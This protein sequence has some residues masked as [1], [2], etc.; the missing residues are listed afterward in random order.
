MFTRERETGIILGAGPVGLYG[1]FILLNQG[2]DVVMYEPRQNFMERN[3]IIQINTQQSP[4]NTFGSQDRW[5]LMYPA[6]HEALAEVACSGHT[7]NPDTFWW[8]GSCGENHDF[9]RGE[10]AWEFTGEKL[11][12]RERKFSRFPTLK[13]RLKMIQD[14]DLSK[15]VFKTR[16]KLKDPTE[17]GWK[18]E[19]KD[20]GENARVLP[21]GG[22]DQKFEERINNITPEWKDQ[23]LEKYFQAGLNAEVAPDL[24]P[25]IGFPINV[26]QQVLLDLCVKTAKKK[27]VCFHLFVGQEIDVD[28]CPNCEECKQKPTW[29]EYD[30]TKNTCYDGTQPNYNP[31][32]SSISRWKENKNR[33]KC[34]TAPFTKAELNDLLETNPRY[35]L[36]A[37]G[38]GDPGKEFNNWWSNHCKDCD[39]VEIEDI[40]FKNY[41]IVIA[42][43]NDNPKKEIER[44]PKEKNLTKKIDI[45]PVVDPQRR[46]GADQ[47]KFRVFTTRAGGMYLGVLSNAGNTIYE[48]WF[49]RPPWTLHGIRSKVDLEKD[50]NDVIK[51]EVRDTY[52]Q[53]RTKVLKEV[54]EKDLPAGLKADIDKDGVKVRGSPYLY[55]VNTYAFLYNK[56]VIARIGDSG[57]NRHFFTGSSLN[58][59]MLSTLDLLTKCGSVR[60]TAPGT[61]Y[62]SKLK[63]PYTGEWA[64]YTEAKDPQGRKGD[65]KWGAVNQI[66]RGE[67]KDVDPRHCKMD[68]QVANYN[69][70]QKALQTLIPKEID[71]LLRDTKLSP[72]QVE[73]KELHLNCN[74]VLFLNYFRRY[75]KIIDSIR[76]D[77][78]YNNYKQF[79]ENLTML[80]EFAD[81]YYPD[82]LQM[83]AEQSNP[84]Y[85][86]QIINSLLQ[87]EEGELYERWCGRNPVWR[88]MP[89]P[90][91]KG[92][93][94]RD[95]TDLTKSLI[96]MNSTTKKLIDE[97]EKLMLANLRQEEENKNIENV[98]YQYKKFNLDSLLDGVKIDDKIGPI[99]G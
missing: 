67:T 19:V 82:F 98:I 22:G 11:I 86:K 6:L 97:V 25:L 12:K 65:N 9:K 40:M 96:K 31:S 8:P 93:W 88:D 5:I 81:K 64:D 33:K 48:K 75:K 68:H 53:I 52:K 32:L 55:R 23:D 15:N 27:D 2:L 95:Y 80:N 18:R 62:N 24:F 30:E 47:G 63:K 66:L 54:D 43:I 69:K 36:L 20:G 58:T 92:S 7:F 91:W 90:V 79:L 99:L 50:Y 42:D 70:S 78:K 39:N 60:G 1:A 77:K 83:I 14:Y 57:Y 46:G 3:Q 56:T 51:E 17:T 16:T 34:V 21:W 28:E 35:L 45:I 37:I 94:P 89:N 61:L 38:A 72:S 41:G 26:I 71:F 44:Y 59:G 73:S 85:T 87:K 76:F 84:N 29:K 49:G 4:T 13:K 74:L 10:Y